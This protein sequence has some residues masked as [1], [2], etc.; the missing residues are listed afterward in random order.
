M[1]Q[2]VAILAATFLVALPATGLE[3]RDI[4]AAHAE[5][6][7]GA[8]AIEAIQSIAI[9]ITIDEGWVLEGHYRAT[10]AGEMRIDV[11]ADGERLFTEALHQGSAWAMQQGE[12]SGSPITPEEANILGRGIL[13]NIYGLHELEAQG[14]AVTVSS[15]DR[16]DGKSFWVV[17]LLHQDGFEDRYYLDAESLLVVRQRSHH[18]LH[19]AVDPE[20]RRFE[21]RYSDYRE[22][23]GVMFPFLKEKFDLETGE[24]VQRTTT[25]SLTINT[26]DDG[27]DF[28]MP[29]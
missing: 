24:R 17:D 20:I 7:G 28:V 29:Q 4:L 3:S 10:R 9:R 21:S 27:S 23:D 26:L 5:A 22:V 12:T 8:A 18:A 14:V 13:G 6:R 19:P 15:S 1:T 16:V 2:H 11:F 25:Q